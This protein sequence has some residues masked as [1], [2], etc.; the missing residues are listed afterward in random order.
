MRCI[1]LLEDTYEVKTHWGWFRLDAETYKD[2]LAGK[3]WINTT[4]SGARQKPSNSATPPLPQ[5]ITPEAL[6]LRDR[7]TRE[8]VYPLLCELCSGEDVPIPYKARMRD[9]SIN[10]MPLSVRSINCLMRSD[11]GTFGRLWELMKEKG[12]RSVRNLGITSERE[13][14]RNFFLACYARLTQTEQARF[15]Q[16]VLADSHI[17]GNIHDTI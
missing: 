8:G 10:E 14:V 6:Q 2:Y 4:P 12:L 9:L 5:D 1:F 13:I 15:W 11:A 7:A 16:D 17:P 3:L